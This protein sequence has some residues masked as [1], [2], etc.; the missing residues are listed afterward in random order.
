MASSVRFI[1]IPG[2]FLAF[3]FISPL[4][5]IITTAGKHG[6]TFA[7]FKSLHCLGNKNKDPRTSNE[8]FIPRLFSP[9]KRKRVR[10][11]YI[12]TIWPALL[13]LRT[14]NA[15]SWTDRLPSGQLFQEMSFRETLQSGN[16]C[17]NIHL[18]SRRHAFPGY[19]EKKTMFNA[20]SAI[21]N[22]FN[23]FENVHAILPLLGSPEMSINI[24]LF[25]RFRLLLAALFAEMFSAAYSDIL[26][27]NFIFTSTLFIQSLLD[28]I[29]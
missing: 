1:F 11:I 29:Q 5:P 21:C 6:T 20:F 25:K 28:S 19:N 9:R 13:T 4:N 12:A 15:S 18:T 8:L 22:C 10:S 23:S 17:N 14:G 3:P 16:M 26:R 7:S 24:S 2:W 27:V